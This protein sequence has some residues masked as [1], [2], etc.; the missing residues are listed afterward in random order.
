MKLSRFAAAISAP[1]Y[2]LALFLLRERIPGGVPFLLSAA[3]GPL[4]AAYFFVTYLLARNRDDR[5]PDLLPLLVWGSA[6]AMEIHAFVPPVARTGVVP[7]ALFFGLAMKFP[8][9]LSLPAILCVDAWLAAVPGPIEREIFYTS[10]MALIAGGAGIVVRG[11]SRNHGREVNVVQEAI[12]R[13]RTLVLPWEDSGND[14]HPAGGEMTEESSLLRREEELKDG[15][16]EALDRLLGLA[17][18]SHIA[19]IA[20]S[21]SPGSVLHEG[22]LLSRGSPVS[23]EISLPDTYVPLREA[24]VFRKPF[25][26][27]GA[28]ARRYAPWKSGPGSAPAGVAAVPVFREGVVEGVLLAIRDEE[29]LWED[30]V[31]P[32][33]E[34]AGH[35]VGRD[36]ERM[37]EL[38]QGDRYYL[39]GEWY[40]SMVRK[41]AEV[42]TEGDPAEGGG[43]RSRREMVYGET[44]EQVRRQVDADRVLLV[45]SGEDP[46]NGRVAWATS[47][48]GSGPGPERYEPLE[49]SYVGWVIRTG[50]QRI[51]PGTAAPP[52]SQG[53]L[54]G[55]W[56][57]EG[58]RSF[59]LLPVEGRIGFRGALVCAHP[60][61]KRFRKEHAEIA[62]DITR[63][64]QLGLSHVERLESLTKKATTDGLT[65]LSNRKAFLERLAVDLSRLDGRHPCG[66]VMLDI[67]HFKGVNDTYGH[68]FGDVVLRGVASV[69]GKGVR[70]GDTA[71][72]Y[73]GEEFVLYLHMAD[74]ERAREGA[75]R[76]RRM[77]RQI[78]FAHEGK[79]IGVTA[80]FGVA[81]APHHGKGVEELL[82][83][84]DEAL[85][86]SKERGRDRVTVYPG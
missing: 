46:G 25:L 28:G 6:A 27:V 41:M 1:L 62:R 52:R 24:T 43:G 64:M 40:H 85:Y 2:L 3:I 75:E 13:S 30:P 14:G 49:D 73:G 57:R 76:F 63:V 22:I 35:F 10:A 21:V 20:R 16:R 39:R 4:A 33:M 11:K 56:E 48:E 71:G 34:L 69:L 55:T 8:P 82:K 12:A 7:A 29:G 17:G 83:H 47:P 18:A 66:V 19:Y 59:L 50:M 15:I 53:V 70:K 45:E 61:E 80:S 42:G 36:I 31:I 9:T 58:E 68:P 78:R 60:Q 65:G 37:R 81:C 79:E 84:A 5:V 51:F 77:I 74:T 32:A 44:A 23:R 38:H 72:R 67:D 26:E 86:L 54:P